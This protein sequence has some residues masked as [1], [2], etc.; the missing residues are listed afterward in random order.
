MNLVKIFNKL[1]LIIISFELQSKVNK[2]I[3]DGEQQIRIKR[4]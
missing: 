4:P 2:L 1:K 3:F